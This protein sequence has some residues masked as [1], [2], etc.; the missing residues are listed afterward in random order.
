MGHLRPCLGSDT[1]TPWRQPRT[2]SRALDKEASNVAFGAVHAWVS[3]PVEHA[4]RCSTLSVTS[5]A[6][7]SGR[8]RTRERRSARSCPSLV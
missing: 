3:D 5:V 4:S 6:G 2:F 7:S 8:D 1:A